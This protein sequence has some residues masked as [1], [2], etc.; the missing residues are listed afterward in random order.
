MRQFDSEKWIDSKANISLTKNIHTTYEMEHT[1]DFIEI[2]YIFCGE[3][4]QSINGATKHVSKGD[5]LFINFREVHTFYPKG[6]LGVLNILV[7]PEFI[8]TQLHC[9][10][11]ALDILT[12]TSFN[13]FSDLKD[14]MISIFSFSGKDF[15][16]VD[17][18]FENMYMEFCQKPT[19]Y[20][21][22][23]KGY[24]DII[25]VLILRKI[26]DMSENINIHN[27]ISKITPQVL[28]YIEKNYNKKI[29]LE[30]LAERNFYNPSYFS[31]IF[32]SCYGMTLTEYINN[33]RIVM[34]IKYLVETNLSAE[35]ISR[36]VGFHN[37][38]QFY[39]KFL[40][41][42]GKTPNAYRARKSDSEIQ[43][44]KDESK[45]IKEDHIVE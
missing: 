30:E 34:A 16:L 22:T 6:Q 18:L 37:K 10:K 43:D 28:E 29:S 17:T 36:L 15:M 31:T 44:K 38:N 14:D 9:C 20:I 25:L 7:N 39:K 32:K 27:E 26:K 23:L 35:K 5:V 4:Y 11:D 24:L 41:V 3:G 21:T 40:N 42:T 12:L 1:H 2:A 33:K 8:N 45:D 19:G 13:D